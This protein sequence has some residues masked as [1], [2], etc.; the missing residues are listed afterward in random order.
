MAIN[1]KRI[2]RAKIVINNTIIEHVTKFIYLG[3][4]LS[5]YNNQKDIDRNLTKY[6]RLN[7]TLK[8]NF[9]KHIR[10]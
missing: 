10:K 4:N 3:S 5:Q 7:R 1:G 2:L 9:D 8:R 6:K